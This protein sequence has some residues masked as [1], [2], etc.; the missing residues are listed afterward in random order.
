MAAICVPK[1]QNRRNLVKEGFSNDEC[2]RFVN[3]T[4]SYL[5]FRCNTMDLLATITTQIS[6]KITISTNQIKTK[7]NENKKKHKNTKRHFRCCSQNFRIWTITCKISYNCDFLFCMDT[8]TLYTSW[9]SWPI[10]SVIPDTSWCS[11][12]APSLSRHVKS[13]Q[14]HPGTHWPSLQPVVGEQPG[15]HR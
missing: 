5:K 3:N 9:L 1:S 6:T 14:T 12:P 8:F 2:V 11:V 15:K 4:T 7:A 13:G 10:N